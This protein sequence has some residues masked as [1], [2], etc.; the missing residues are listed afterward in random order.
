MLKKLSF[1]NSYSYMEEAKLNMDAK[2]STTNTD[3]D[4]RPLPENV[5]MHEVVRNRVPGAE[6]GILPVAAIYG[7]NAGGKTK[8]LKTIGDIASDVLGDTFSAVTVHSSLTPFEQIVSKRQFTLVDEDRINKTIEYAIQVVIDNIEYMMEYSLDSKGI[9]KEKVTMRKNQH[10]ASEVMLYSRNGL[11]FEEGSDETINSYL[12]LM[13]NRGEA[14]LW[15]PLIAPA[16]KGL[17]SVYEWFRRVRDGMVLNH[18]VHEEKMFKEIASRIRD[19][20]DEPFRKKLLRFLKHLD[21]SVEDIEGKIS[22]NNPILWVY[23]NNKY[24]QNGV[25]SIWAHMI[26]DESAGT[27]RLIEI[28]P[29]IDRV[30]EQGMPFICDELD[31][32]LHPVVF[33]Q[34]VRMFNSPEI[35]KNNAQLIFTA[36]DTIVL[37]SDLLRQDEVH[38]VNKNKIAISSIE[39][40]SDMAGVEDYTDMER[41]FRTGFYGSF[42]NDFSNS[43]GGV[44]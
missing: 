35:N 26:E 16:K 7:K 43:Y 28:F 44:N 30:L 27:R 5:I 34:L 14:Q 24:N 12:T 36:H 6:S 8:L 29:L 11:D 38:I 40:L 22:Q 10:N 21:E 15:F 32:V 17:K 1:C 31:R 33:K 25:G 39:R 9:K 20:K 37:D 19:K 13:K 4:G 3:E 2:L 42:P 23:H 18:A 41:D